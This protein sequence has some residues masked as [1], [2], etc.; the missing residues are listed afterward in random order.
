MKI[1]FSSKNMY[2]VKPIKKYA[3]FYTENINNVE[4][5]RWISS[6]PTIYTIEEEINWIKSIKDEP[7]F[8]IFNKNKEIIGNISFNSIKNNIGVIGIWITPSMQNK[9]YG[10]E[11]IEEMIEYGFNKMN[12]KRI[13][14]VV[15]ENNIKAIKCYESVGFKKYRTKFNVKD[16]IGTIT[17]N[18]YMKIEKER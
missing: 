10:R 18:I 17:N 7:I 5:Y 6:N 1:I 16:G 12:I 9:H 13:N 14:I 8:T 2:F 11:A 15:F 3:E 4:I